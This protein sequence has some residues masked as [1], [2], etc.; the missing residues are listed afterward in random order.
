MNSDSKEK[1]IVDSQVAADAQAEVKTSPTTLRIAFASD[2]YNL[3]KTE[4][5][6][7]CALTNYYAY[8]R[9]GR[10]LFSVSP[11]AEVEFRIAFTS[12]N[13]NLTKTEFER[14]CELTDYYAKEGKEIISYCSA[15]GRNP[16]LF[17]RGNVWR[18]EWVNDFVNMLS[19]KKYNNVNRMRLFAWQFSAYRVGDLTSGSPWIGRPQNG[20][21]TCTI[22][23]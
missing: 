21:R 20:F 3:T 1:A 23:K 12:D 16:N 15:R 7:Y 10:Q 5:D 9:T 4:F 2:N 11:P 19:S 6:R 14:C 8:Y 17:D 22:L 18:G 13:H